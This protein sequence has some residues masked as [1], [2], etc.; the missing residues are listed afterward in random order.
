MKKE[1]E[2]YKRQLNFY[3][4]KM[5]IDL[6]NN[7]RK[8]ENS[9]NLDYNRQGNVYSP[10]KS[11]KIYKTLNTSK[12]KKKDDISKHVNYEEINL[13]EFS[14]K[15]E[16]NDS[17][18]NS[19]NEETRN[20]K[21]ENL[22]ICNN[23][24]SIQ[25][26]SC[27]YLNSKNT[28]EKENPNFSFFENKRK[29]NLSPYKDKNDICKINSIQ[30]KRYSD[31]KTNESVLKRKLEDNI[32]FK[33]SE[34]EKIIQNNCQNIYNLNINPIGNKII[35]FNLFKHIFYWCIKLFNF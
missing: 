30:I 1:I 4:E 5:K 20:V 3:K 15:L 23:S 18:L 12:V 7:T 31:N 34:N 22:T 10:K 17:N 8:F 16:N 11:R 14:V 24:N 13:N 6:S 32:N 2:S 21:I 33:K 26:Q 35:C 29:L 25:N 27:L 19:K 9:S 28:N